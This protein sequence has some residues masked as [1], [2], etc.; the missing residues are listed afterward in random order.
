MHPSN[1][2]MQCPKSCTSFRRG[3]KARYEWQWSVFFSIIYLFFIFLWVAVILKF[4]TSTRHLKFQWY[5]K[6]FY[7]VIQLINTTY[8]LKDRLR[9]I[10]LIYFFNLLIIGW[11]PTYPPSC[12]LQFGRQYFGFWYEMKIH[13]LKSFIR[14]LAAIAGLFFFY[15]I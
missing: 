11:M 4:S 6:L 3:V 13:T 14:F 5:L 15:F 1:S 2:L 10:K 12:N 9:S 8:H 7:S